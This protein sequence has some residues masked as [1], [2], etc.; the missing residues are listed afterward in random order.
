MNLENHR[1]VFSNRALVVTKGR[2]V[3]RAYF[4]QLTA[5]RLD[6]F[7]DTKAAADLHE[8][9]AGND[10]FGF[11]R[12]E[13]PDNENERPCALVNDR[14]RLCSATESERPFQISAA[15]PTVTTRKIIFEVGVSAGDFAEQFR[16]AMCDR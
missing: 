6:D 14:S 8:L 9:A 10:D 15:V 4:T 11:R 3:R 5:G 13:I 7:A 12:S 2:F 1:G 16:L